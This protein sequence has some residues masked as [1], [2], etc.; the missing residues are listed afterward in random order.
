MTLN[1]NE[2]EEIKI[3]FSWT[4]LHYVVNQ[5]VCGMDNKYKVSFVNSKLES[6]M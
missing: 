4:E 6:N 2:Y 1:Q 5:T 3:Y